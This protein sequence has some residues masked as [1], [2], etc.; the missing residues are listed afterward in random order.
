MVPQDL[1]K[2]DMSLTFTKMT[3]LNVI[4]CHTVAV[5]SV[6]NGQTMS[7]AVKQASCQ[8]L[9]S[10]G[11]SFPSLGTCISERAAVPETKD[12]GVRDNKMDGKKQHRGFLL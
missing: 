2:V 8:F 11:P 6:D 5:P 12:K 9:P 4:S 3:I 10:E 1:V 7:R